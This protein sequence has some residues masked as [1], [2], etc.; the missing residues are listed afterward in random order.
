MY[1]QSKLCNVLQRNLK[2]CY[3]AVFNKIIKINIFIKYY[4]II[5]KL[6]IR[7]IFEVVT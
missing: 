4:S 5:L 2:Q 3:S 1:Y 7:M 6:N